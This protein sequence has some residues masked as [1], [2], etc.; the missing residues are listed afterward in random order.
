MARIRDDEDDRPA[1]RSRDDDS[2][3]RRER[4][5]IRDDADEKPRRARDD[6][7]E[8]PRRSRSR[9]DDADEKPRARSRDDADEKPRRARDD[10]ADEKPARGKSEGRGY[11][12][13]N[14]NQ[15]RDRANMKGGDFDS[16]IK[17]KFKVYKIREGKNIIRILPATWADAEHYGFDLWVN[18]GI[19]ADKQ[20]YLSLSKM[21]GEKDPL[22]EAR[23]QA[24]RDGDKKVAKA[25]TPRQRVGMWVIDRQDEDEGPQFFNA[26]FTLDRDIANICY[27]EDTKEF[28][29]LEDPEEGCDFKFIKEGKSLNT[30]YP[31]SQMKL[32]KPS[33]L[34]D[35][36]DQMDEWLDFAKDNPVPTAL[37]YYDYDHIAN[38]FDGHVEVRDDDDDEKPRRG[39][40]RDDADEKPRRSR[41]DDADEKPRR[42]RDA[43][44]DEKPRSR[45]RDDDDPPF[46]ADEKPSRS[47]KRDDD[48][49]EDLPRGGKKDDDEG[50]S[51]RDK[52]NRRR[53][54]IED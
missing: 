49:E 22:A 38:V 39:R 13:R 25:L 36:P 18:Y 7:E 45:K 34:S 30:K 41:D 4:S 3:D 33:P 15:G 42:A 32:F 53:R 1:R 17:S 48:A 51:V 10:D 52:L 24:D 12:K 5:R 54:Q 2:G 31:A 14:A 28:V 27:D 9:D 8:P 44:A 16:I 50:G 26:P 35:D 40:G 6:D 19:G 29:A 23:K 20:S 47:R 21:K 11:L 43:D 46:D 37:Q